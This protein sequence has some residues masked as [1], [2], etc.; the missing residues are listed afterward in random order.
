MKRIF[1]VLVL[2]QSALLGFSIERVSPK[3]VGMDSVRLSKVD[4]IINTSIAK[5]EIPGADRKSV[6]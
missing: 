4:G 5:G 1:L 3:S 2:L 6:V